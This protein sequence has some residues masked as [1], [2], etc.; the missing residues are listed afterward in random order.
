MSFQK[1]AMMWLV[2]FG[3]AWGS[4]SAAEPEAV[5]EMPE[6]SAA[7]A[8]IIVTEEDISDRPYR[9][10]GQVFVRAK[11][12][13]IIDRPPIEE[14]VDILLRADAAGLG[15]DA[16]INVRRERNGVSVFNL[17]YMDGIGTA[18]AFGGSSTAATAPQTVPDA[19]SR[20]QTGAAPQVAARPPAGANPVDPLTSFLNAV[21]AGN[22]DATSA[23]F[24]DDASIED[25]AGSRPIAGRGAVE[26]YIAGL[27]ARG[28]RFEMVLPVG[29]SGMGAAAMAVRVHTGSSV[30]ST[31]HAFTYGPNGMIS[32][33]TIYRDPTLR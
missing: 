14:K 5:M 3:L 21:N 24:A 9:V 33:L 32:K 6:L 13:G 18:V 12:V 17:G 2:G 8:K 22:A 16:V 1:F 19:P 31:I 28:A 7:A 27:M 20:P 23:L 11:K 29:N 15:A 4:A 25:P 26:S 30:E 10:L